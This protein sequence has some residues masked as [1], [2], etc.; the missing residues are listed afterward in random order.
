M[1]F[2]LRLSRNNEVTSNKKTSSGLLAAGGMAAIVASSCC[3]G[4]LVL[5]LLGFSG[6]WIGNLTRMEPYRPWFLL[7]TIIALAFAARRI[8][9]PVY[10]CAP[11]EFCARPVSQD[12]SKIAFGAVTV[13]ALIALVFPYLARFFY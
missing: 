8:F 6:A 4:P 1:Q 9:R 10:E 3:L 5:V 2:Q 7:L 12:I 13:L 11:D